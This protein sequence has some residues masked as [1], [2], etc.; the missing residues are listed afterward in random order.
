MKKCFKCNNEKPL[1]EF[2]RHAGMK[3]GHLNKCKLCTKKDV[4]LDR[5]NSP[6]AREYDRK[7]WRENAL[8]RKKMIDRA[9]EWR[10]KNSLGY[11][12]HYSVSNAIRDGRLKR[13]PC[14]VCG[15]KRVHAHHDD[16]SM[17]LNVRWLCPAH[18]QQLHHDEG[19]LHDS[20]W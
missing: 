5:A 15:E 18:H 16:Y 17:P 3:D 4:R 2:Y 10:K 19:L 13:M 11:K 12:A 6:N 9:K 8:R 14:E 20:I 1:S 7:R